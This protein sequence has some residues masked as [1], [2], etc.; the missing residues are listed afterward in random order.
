MFRQYYADRFRSMYPPVPKK[1][2]RKTVYYK[3]PRDRQI[4]T[5]PIGTILYIQDGINPL[6][7]FTAPIVC[8]E[9]WIVEAWIPRN[10]AQWDAATR[11]FRNVRIRGGHLAVVRS[12]RSQRTTTVADWILL[13]CADAG[14]DWQLRQRT[15]I[16]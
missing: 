12:L 9:P 5:I 2:G 13:A 16:S 8:R 1:V 15:T 10:Y 4:G 3:D 11:R 14:L 7:G 6:K